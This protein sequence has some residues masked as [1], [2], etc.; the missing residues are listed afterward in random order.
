MY[1]QINGGGPGR[2]ADDAAHREHY[3]A[4]CLDAIVPAL[5][6]L[7]TIA[8]PKNINVIGCEIAAR[9]WIAGGDWDKYD[10]MILQFAG[11]HPH[12]QVYIVERGP[13]ARVNGQPIP[14]VH[15]HRVPQSQSSTSVPTSSASHC[16]SD[17][18]ASSQ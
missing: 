14:P 17:A 2:G 12:L 18:D 11:L 1:A 4:C 7:V 3:F 9:V 16:R 10:R 13:I 5:P 15:H 8:F 6:R